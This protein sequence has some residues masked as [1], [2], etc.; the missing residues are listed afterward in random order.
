MAAHFTIKEVIPQNL[1]VPKSKTKTITS[2]NTLN[3]QFVNE[4]LWS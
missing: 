1:Q 4:F 2:Q 3:R